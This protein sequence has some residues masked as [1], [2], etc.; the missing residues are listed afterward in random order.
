MPTVILP[1]ARRSPGAALGALADAARLHADRRRQRLARRIG[2]DRAAARRARRRPSRCAASAP[3]A[4]P[5]SSRPATTSCA[6]WTATRRSIR[7]TSRRS[8]ARCSS[9]PPTSCSA[10][11]AASAAAMPPHAR[12]ANRLLVLELRRRS[13]VVLRDL[14]PMRAARRGPLVELAIEDRR[15]GWPLEMVLRAAAEGWRI[16]RGRGAL[17][18]A[19]RALEGDR[20][21]ARH[22][23]RRARH[24]GGADMTAIA[25][26]REGAG[27][28][29]Q[30]DA[31]DA[32]RAA[33]SRR[34][35]W[36]RRRSQDTLAAVAAT[37]VARRIVVLD[38]APGRGCAPGFEVIAQRGGRSRRAARCRVR[39]HR[40]AGAGRG[41][42]HA[43]AHA[44][45][46]G[47]CAAPARARRRG[48]RRRSRRRLLGDRPA[49]RRRRPS[50]R[51]CR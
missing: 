51:A 34:R 10:P 33:P 35:R 3:P 32:R 1:G 38:G 44:A 13:G 12:L 6:S 4:T 46:A 24:G 41:D 15:F 7:A 8:P 23:A 19:R 25:V 37:A 27:R 22:R 28:R 26:H 43:A 39:R 31:A 5:A 17:C 48:A 21:R 14:G 29:A 36:R 50:S 20:H 49:P 45:A 42:G 11:A 47:V 18:A 9:R 2:A 40:R 16:A 30:Q